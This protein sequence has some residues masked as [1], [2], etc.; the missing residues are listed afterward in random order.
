MFW[1]RRA[2]IIP[3]GLYVEARLKKIELNLKNLND[4]GNDKVVKVG[5]N[6]VSREIL[7]RSVFPF[8][9]ESIITSESIRRYNIR[10]K[11]SLMPEH[12]FYVDKHDAIKALS[13][14]MENDMKA[15]K[16]KMLKAK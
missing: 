7:E 16:E 3:E 14:M 4:D 5:V 1:G 2:K 9:S 10:T 6:Y 13:A 8:T 12:T 15:E 11:Y